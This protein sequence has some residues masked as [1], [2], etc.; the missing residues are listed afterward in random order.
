[1]TGDYFVSVD[2]GGGALPSPGSADAFL[3]KFGP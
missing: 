2:F 1:L 3:A